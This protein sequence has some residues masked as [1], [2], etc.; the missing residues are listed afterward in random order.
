MIFGFEDEQCEKAWEM[1]QEFKKYAKTDGMDYLAFD[2]LIL[3]CRLIN[4]QQASPAL[5]DRF[6]KAMGWQAYHIEGDAKSQDGKI[7]EIKVSILD[8]VNL[9]PNIRQVRLFENI[10]SYYVFII[11]KNNK[12][13]VYKLTYRQMEHEVELSGW[14]CTHPR[15]G[16]NGELKSK[17]YNV[18]FQDNWNELYKIDSRPF[19]KT[20]KRSVDM[21]V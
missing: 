3:Y 18:T 8:S 7:I 14:S 1:K 19:R 16:K 17:E 11:D 12:L 13:R 6:R 15:D 9:T 10:D 5:E 21:F 4:S 20:I 2:K